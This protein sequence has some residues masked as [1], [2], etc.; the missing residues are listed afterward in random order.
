[1]RL[2][3]TCRAVVAM[4]SLS[5]VS[6]GFAQAAH[7]G[8]IGTEAVA[9]ASQRA[10]QEARIQGLIASDDVQGQLVALGVDPAWASARVASLTDEEL[11][12]LDGRLAEMPAGGDVVAL[13][14]AVF[15][16]L[17]ILELTG[18]IDIFKR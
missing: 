13:V 4:V 17:I 15:I 2:A 5:M 12:R 6:L 10:A 1:M 11:A 16:V 3:N 9:A 7:A 18:V 14:G 8:V